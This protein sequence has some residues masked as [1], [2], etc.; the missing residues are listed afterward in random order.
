MTDTALIII[1]VQNG[2]FTHSEQPFEGARMLAHIDALVQR[3]RSASVPVIFVQHDGGSGHPLEKM[4]DGWQI[5]PATGYRAGDVVIEK[6]Y[7]DAFHAT[8]LHE[9]LQ[10]NHVQNIVIAGMMTQYCVDTSCR[11]A[12][13][14]GYKVVLASDAHS[15]FSHGELSAAQIIAHHNMILGNDFA[16]TRAA[17]DIDFQ[18]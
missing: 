1:D 13:S 14:L 6:R 2:M 17:N 12:F 9:H 16:T 11:R 18:P 7:C 8:T 5:H 10:R 3:A 15:T 4:T